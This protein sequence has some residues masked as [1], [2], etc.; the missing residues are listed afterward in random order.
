[1]FVLFSDPCSVVHQGMKAQPGSHGLRGSPQTP[2]TRFPTSVLQSTVMPLSPYNALKSLASRVVAYHYCQAEN[3]ITC[4]VPEFVHS[5]AAYMANAPQLATYRERLVRDSKLQAALSVRECLSDPSRAFVKGIIEPLTELSIAG[6]LGDQVCVILVDA[7][8]E[9]AFHEPDYGHTIASFLAAHVHRFPVWLKVIVTVRT[10]LQEI[11]KSL[12]SFH[13]ICLDSGSEGVAR[14]LLGYVNHRIAT[15]PSIQSNVELNSKLESSTQARLSAHIVSLSQAC[16]LYCKLVLDL[17]EHGPLVLKSSNY[18]IL[19]VNL[20]EVFLLQ[21]NMRFHTS[22]SFDKVS[23]ILNV[24]LA[25]LY[26]L[27]I[28]EIFQVFN[29]GLLYRYVDWHDFVQR[30]ESLSGFLL[31]RKDGTYVFF[32][33]AF[34][35]WLIRRDDNESQKYLCD[36]RSASDNVEISAQFS[37]LIRLDNV[38]ISLLM[39]FKYICDLK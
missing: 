16:F 3:N 19:P 13:R 25:S 29:S 37:F 26:P 10:V 31:R 30:I 11:T 2:V 7:L 38:D 21:F 33:P 22:R 12:P 5:L 9:A 23:P 15:T 4:M 36:L 32:H 14:D 18:K 1:M 28:E 35:E 24:C 20:C 27:T 17:I 34:R 39:K 8:N 6:Q